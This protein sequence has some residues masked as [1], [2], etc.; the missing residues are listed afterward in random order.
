MAVSLA[1][2]A[3]HKLIHCRQNMGSDVESR[4]RQASQDG[5][6]RPGRS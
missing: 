6:G 5:D 1:T 3:A 4:T 2:V